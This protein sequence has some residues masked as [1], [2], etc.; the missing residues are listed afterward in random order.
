MNCWDPSRPGRREDVCCL[1]LRSSSDH[2]EHP[3]FN[4]T[5]IT[6]T[7]LRV[8]GHAHRSAHVEVIGQP[9]AVDPLLPMHV[10][11]AELGSLGLDQ[12]HYPF[13]HLAGLRTFLCAWPVYMIMY[14]HMHVQTRSRDKCHRCHC[15]LLPPLALQLILLRPRPS[16]H[17]SSLN[18]LGRMAG[19]LQD[20]PACPALTCPAA[21]AGDQTH[22]MHLAL[23]WPSP[24]LD[25]LTGQMAW[26][27]G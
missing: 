18:Q 24:V 20:L 4:Q 21:P 3:F 26:W 15:H 23:H 9:A 14:A 17:M 11:R 1:G 16:L 13:S 27:F 8:W 7:Y 22:M 19:K 25:I 5:F 6:I 10:P 2:G 12:H